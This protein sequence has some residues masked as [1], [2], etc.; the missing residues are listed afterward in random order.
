MCWKTVVIAGTNQ[1]YLLRY[2][3]ITNGTIIFENKRT[4]KPKDH[5]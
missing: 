3:E 5:L 2:E 1:I 4:D